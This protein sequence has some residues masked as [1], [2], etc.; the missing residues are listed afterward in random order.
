MACPG[1]PPRRRHRWLPA[2]HMWHLPPP[3]LPPRQTLL[4]ALRP[5][6][7]PG[8]S[9]RQ[10]RRRPMGVGEQGRQRYL[11]LPASTMVRS[12]TGRPHGP[13]PTI[14][15][16]DSTPRRPPADLRHRTAAPSSPSTGAPRQLGA[17]A[18][19]LGHTPC[20]AMPRGCPGLGAGPLRASSPTPP[21]TA[22]P[23]RPRLIPLRGR[24]SRKGRPLDAGGLHEQEFLPVPSC[25]TLLPC[26]AVRG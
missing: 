1:Q 23:A 3:L 14:V 2:R 22:T 10:Q 17:D 15:G 6:G 16:P 8:R 25:L 12:A 20:R 26:Q 21:T 11:P 13:A 7:A 9:R 19:Q 5:R 4:R 18:G 24:R